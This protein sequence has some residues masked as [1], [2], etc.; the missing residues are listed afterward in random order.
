MSSPSAIVR[1]T[2][3][4]HLKLIETHSAN[5]TLDF[6]QEYEQCEVDCIRSYDRDQ[7]QYLIDTFNQKMVKIVLYCVFV[8]LLVGVFFLCKNYD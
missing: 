3:D 8:L 4:C 7:D 2:V 5:K 6:N 1:C